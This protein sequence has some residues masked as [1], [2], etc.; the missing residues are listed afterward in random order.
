MLFGS[1]ALAPDVLY[2][3]GLVSKNWAHGVWANIF[4]F[5]GALEQ[6]EHTAPGLDKKLCVTGN[7]AWAFIYIGVT[8]GYVLFIAGLKKRIKAI[9]ETKRY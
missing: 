7:F 1:W 8:T 4:F 2:A 9:K 6:L 5:H 3:L